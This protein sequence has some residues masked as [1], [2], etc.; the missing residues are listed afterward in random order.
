MK[1]E[2]NTLKSVVLF[3]IYLAYA[4]IYVA[5]INLT[6]AGP[7][8]INNGVLDAV[9]LGALGSAFSVIY[10]LGRLCNGILSDRVAPWIMLTVGLGLSGCANLLFSLFP[11]F[12]A[13]FLLWSVNAF[14]QSMLWSSVLCVISALY[15]PEIAQKKS[16]IVITTVATGNIIAILMNGWLISRV[17]VR[18][19]F[20]IPGGITL[21]LGIFVL[22]LTK[23][24][25]PQRNKVE[26]KYRFYLMRDSELRIRLIPAFFHGVMKDNI[27]LWMTVYVVSTF[28]VNLE[29]SSLYILLIP[30][31]GFVGRSVYS[32]VYK[33]LGNSE[34]AVSRFG[35]IV[36]IAA[37]GLLCFKG[38]GLV[39]AV[40]ALSTVYATVSLINTSF[41]SV[42]PLSFAERGSVA[43]V[44][45]LMDFATYLGAGISG[46]FYGILIKSFGYV[47]MFFSW[48]VVSLISYGILLK[49]RKE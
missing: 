11:P 47:P 26:K 24:I 15:S 40:V 28:G 20:L 3:V 49:Y 34:S 19:A 25:V 2:N 31:M 37:S 8:L 42:Y 4:S 32:L 46:V 12:L 16:S 21:I 17:G 43:S 7:T 38:I 44:S 27:G 33:W 45:G 5:R 39:T 23:N 36:C 13:I 1:T 22:L 48:S 18:F 35:F 10:A 41:L 30:T 29:K 14:A 9:K 6:M